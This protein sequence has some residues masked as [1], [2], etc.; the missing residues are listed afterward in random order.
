MIPV[1]LIIIVII[2]LI[3]IGVGIA[4][5]K[6]CKEK[7]CTCCHN[8]NY[9]TFFIVGAAFIPIGIATKNPALWTVGLVFIALGLTK[10]EEVKKKWA[11]WKKKKKRK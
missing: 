9:N 11:D 8:Q 5:S 7:N 3:A 6:K 4:Q 2:G 10:N 1:I